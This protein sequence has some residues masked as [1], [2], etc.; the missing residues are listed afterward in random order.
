MTSGSET[1]QHHPLDARLLMTAGVDYRCS[2]TASTPKRLRPNAFLP[3]Q[4]LLIPV[5]TIA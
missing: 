2:I 4:T 5:P 3:D 1:I